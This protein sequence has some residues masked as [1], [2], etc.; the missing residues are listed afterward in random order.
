MLPVWT[1]VETAAA[2]VPAE[3]PRPVAERRDEA[4]PLT[5]DLRRLHVT[6]SRHFLAKLDAARDALS[7]SHPGASIEEILEVGLDLVLERSAKRKGLVKKPLKVPRQSKGDGIPAQVR[8]AVWVRD[9]GR[10]QW[11]LQTGGICGST[12]RVEVDHVEEKARGGPPTVENTRLVCD[13]HNIRKARVVFGDAW[14][15]RFT[16]KARRG[17]ARP[18]R[19]PPEIPASG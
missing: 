19:G 13:V 16:R 15:D 14:M 6:V 12:Y 11:P 18:Q 8:R 2:P 3:A 1:P 5:A 4:V 17:D 9:G 7:H 10:C